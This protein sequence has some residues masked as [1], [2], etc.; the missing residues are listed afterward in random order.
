MDTGRYDGFEIDIDTARRAS[1]ALLDENARVTMNLFELI[2]ENP[3]SRAWSDQAQF[4]ICQTNAQTPVWAWLSETMDSKTATQAAAI[5]AA[6]IA[7]NATV[8]LNVSPRQGAAV[9]RNICKDYGFEP[10]KIMDMNAYI[11]R[12]LV[13]PKNH[14]FAAQPSETDKAAVAA[15]LR[16][17]VEDGE[18]QTISPEAADA[19]AAAAVGSNQLSLWQDNG[20][21]AMAMLAHC[22]ATT[23]RIN[24]VVTDRARRGCGYAGMLTAHIC[25]ELLAKGVVPMLYVDA[26]NPSSNREY[27]KIGFEKVGEVTEYTFVQA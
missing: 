10:R 14:G 25:A 19:F 18:G 20:V 2:L 26:A 6:R 7:E 3:K 12:K 5:I 24:T 21:C 16:Q 23:A 27:R 13:L 8:H 15:L 17:L 4:L 9:L 1:R 22:T 11:C